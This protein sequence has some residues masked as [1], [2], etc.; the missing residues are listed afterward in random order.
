M[1]E[2]TIDAQPPAE[3]RDELAALRTALDLRIPRKQLDKNLLIA[4]WNIRSFASV[5]KKWLAGAGDSPKRDYR[6][7]LAIREIVSRFDVIAIQEVKGDLRA[8]RYLMKAL[9]EHWSFLMSDVTAGDAGNDERL[10]FVFDRRRIELS[11]MAGEIVIPPE[12]DVPESALREQFARTPY[13]VSF[14]SAGTTLILVTAHIKFGSHPD[15]RRPEIA[16]IAEWLYEWA[17]RANRW[18]HNLI[19]LGDF[20]I[21]RKG[22]PLFEAL[23]E[24]GLTVPASLI[25]LP[26]SIFADADEPTKS[27]YYD[28]IAWFHKPGSKRRLDMDPLAG[29]HFDFVPHVYKGAGLDRTSVSWRLSDHYPLWVEFALPD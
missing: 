26:R 5:T 8:L 27:K 10:A 3:V 25:D 14:R 2:L 6:G 22:D 20:N 15:E 17:G 21:D 9:G 18:H 13:A 19:A 29:G 23:I 12:W 4:T 16:G 7:L 28:Q 11:G 24:R 1:P